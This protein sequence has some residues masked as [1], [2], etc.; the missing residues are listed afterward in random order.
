MT[1]NILN[2][3]IQWNKWQQALFHFVLFIIVFF[4]IQLIIMLFR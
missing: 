1:T 3:Y 4:A 2:K